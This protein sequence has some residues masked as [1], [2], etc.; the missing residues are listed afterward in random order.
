MMR[1]IN[2]TE[3]R[4]AQ[5]LGGSKSTNVWDVKL[6]QVG[7][8][9]VAPTK[10]SIVPRWLLV[11]PRQPFL[12]FSHYASRKKI[13]PLQLVSATA[14]AVSSKDDWLWFEHGPSS[15]NTEIGCGVDHAHI[16]LIYEPSF[17]FDDFSNEV[18]GLSGVRWENVSPH[19]T[20]EGIGSD[21][22]YYIFGN[23]VEVFRVKGRNFGSQFFRKVVAKIAG[24]HDQW[25]YKVHPHVTNVR[26]TLSRFSHINEAA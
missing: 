18:F 15:M 20:H 21:E 17:S 16:H 19:T 8:C 4:F 9:V 5:L 13:K 2:S 25:D 23:G 3:N 24:R 22:S 26:E 6:L 7:D 14:E 12:N 10:G 11:V 1:S